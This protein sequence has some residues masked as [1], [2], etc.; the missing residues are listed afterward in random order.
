MGGECASHGT[1]ISCNIEKIMAALWTFRAALGIFSISCAFFLRRQKSDGTWWDHGAQETQVSRLK[2]NVRGSSS[3][4]SPGANMLVYSVYSQPRAPKQLSVCCFTTSSFNS[5]SM[6]TSPSSPEWKT[7]L[8]ILS[9]TNIDSARGSQTYS[10]YILLIYKH[11]FAILNHI[12]TNSVHLQLSTLV[13]DRFT[14]CA[15]MAL[16]CPSSDTTAATRL[17]SEL[18]SERSRA[19]GTWQLRPTL[20]KCGSSYF[21]AASTTPYGTNTH[22]QHLDLLWPARCKNTHSLRSKSV[23]IVWMRLLSTCRTVEVIFM[24]YHIIEY[25]HC[26]KHSMSCRLHILPRPATATSRLTQA[27]L[28]PAFQLPAPSRSA[29]PEWRDRWWKWWDG[30][31]V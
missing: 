23:W 26:D 13:P 2:S 17:R 9:P 18:R 12:H 5:S 3:M 15:A 30:G 7:A 25:W 19:A 10:W 29:A 27:P 24:F 20:C 31:F 8:L 4:P 6:E 28:H 22:A 21:Q 16:I 1:S 11:S 14:C